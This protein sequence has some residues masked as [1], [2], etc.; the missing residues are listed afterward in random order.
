MQEIQGGQD[1]AWS[2]FP[3]E[4]EAQ[5]GGALRQE[6]KGGCEKFC[7]LAKEETL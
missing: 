2:C 1:D 7:S 3:P 4:K 5:V 6:D